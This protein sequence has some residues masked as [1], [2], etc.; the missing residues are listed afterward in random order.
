MGGKDG[1]QTKRKEK[2]LG[3]LPSPFLIYG[4]PCKVN[5]GTWKVV[6]NLH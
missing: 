3:R 1:V 5:V 6:I 2:G 4:E